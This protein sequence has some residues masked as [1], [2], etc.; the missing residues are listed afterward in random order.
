FSNGTLSG[1]RFGY[2]S[3]YY[4]AKKQFNASARQLPT[5]PD[6]GKITGTSGSEYVIC[7][8]APERKWN[9]REAR[10]LLDFIRRGGTAIIVAPTDNHLA[11][12]AS[13]FKIL[14]FTFKS[15]S[16]ESEPAI[17]PF[18]SP[19]RQISLSPSISTHYRI[20]ASSYIRVGSSSTN[21]VFSDNSIINVYYD[22][23][24]NPVV[25]AL[26]RDEWNGGK[27]FWICGALPGYNGEAGD[28]DFKESYLRHLARKYGLSTHMWDSVKQRIREKLEEKNEAGLEGA[29]IPDQKNLSRIKSGINLFE[30]LVAGDPESESPK[31]LVF[32]DYLKEQSDTTEVLALLSSGALYAVILTAVLVFT[33]L[34]FFVRG[35]PPVN[36]IREMKSAQRDDP[37]PPDEIDP[38][39]L[40]QGR[41]RFPAQLIHIESELNKLPKER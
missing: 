34:L 3:L 15:Q 5:Y 41:T 25:N 22:S 21:N 37:Y 36:A 10:A 7:I 39:V 8:N 32:F 16:S 11:N 13:F 35:K 2:S 28:P 19:Y 33:G 23:D 6:E 17:R 1:S 4:A 20:P 26:S 9:D 38:Q 27:V 24:G 14:G 40:R 31:T 18:L 12:T 29:V 30:G